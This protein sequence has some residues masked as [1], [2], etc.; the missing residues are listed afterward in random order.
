MRPLVCTPVCTSHQR[1]SAL[2]T[3]QE[4]IE[5][6]TSDKVDVWAV[7]ILAYELLVG[8]PPFERDTRE[9]TGASIQHSEPLWPP[10][11]TDAA[12]DFTQRALSKVVV[13]VVARCACCGMWGC[14]H[15][16]GAAAAPAGSCCRQSL[17][18]ARGLRE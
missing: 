17:V 9:E 6:T 11:M 2:P 1:P 16:G 10:W 12:R 3:P 14:G 7:G 18:R 5:L 8:R 4:R 13:V 15:V